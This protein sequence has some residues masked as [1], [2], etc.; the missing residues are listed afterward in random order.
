M[1]SAPGW[2]VLGKETF[3]LDIGPVWKEEIVKALS[4]AEG[5]D[6]FKKLMDKSEVMHLFNG[7]TE[8]HNFIIEVPEKTKPKDIQFMA[9]LILGYAQNNLENYFVSLGDEYQKSQVIITNDKEPELIGKDRTE[10]YTSGKIF[11]PIFESLSKP[12]RMNESD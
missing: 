11:M 5:G 8:I 3:Y 4:T 2:K 6:K 1:S 10:G 12:G 7:T 9:D